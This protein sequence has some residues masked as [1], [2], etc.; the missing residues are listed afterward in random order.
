MTDVL[1]P[2]RD[3]RPA[4][5]RSAPRRIWLR[6]AGCLLLA[7]VPVLA[8]F[9]VVGQRAGNST[10]SSPAAAVVVRAPA[11]TRGGLMYQAK[12]TIVARRTLKS[13]SLVLGNGWLDGM[14]MNT[15]EPSASSETTGPH[16]GLTLSLGTLNA[17]Q[18]Y[19]QY[20][21]FQ[22]NP[23]SVGTRSQPVML[24]SAG[25]TLLSLTHRMTVFP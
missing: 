6:R 12:F 16:G 2:V 7:A 15:D 19:V 21:E 23:T 4:D 5:D 24:R 8:L 13:V 20:F 25:T 17:G 18:T 14:T 11:A 22:V 10:V 3:V 1:Q 9:N